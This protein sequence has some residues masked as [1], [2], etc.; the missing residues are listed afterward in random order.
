MKPLKIRSKI[1][2]K[3]VVNYYGEIILKNPKRKTHKLHKNKS[4]FRYFNYVP[5]GHKNFDK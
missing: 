5:V 3:K 1:I 2:L 4:P